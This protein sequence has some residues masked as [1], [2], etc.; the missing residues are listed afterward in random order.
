MEIVHLDLFINVDFPK[1]LGA[2]CGFFSGFEIS[3]KFCIFAT[4]L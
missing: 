2:F 1:F 3:I 4:I